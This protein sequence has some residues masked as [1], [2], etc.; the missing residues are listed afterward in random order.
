MSLPADDTEPILA[1]EPNPLDQAEGGCI[2]GFVSIVGALN[3]DGLLN[4]TARNETS[5]VFSCQA[6]PGAR[7][8]RFLAMDHIYAKSQISC[9][10]S[11]SFPG[12]FP[13]MLPF[14]V[15]SRNQTRHP[16]H[17]P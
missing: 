10:F 8:G 1:F 12:E 15:P 9:A 4:V 13:A 3:L 14:P 6:E 17:S 16:V 5:A 2:N 11:S 7:V